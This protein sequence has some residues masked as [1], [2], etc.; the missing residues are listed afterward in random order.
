MAF[1]MLWVP[2]ALSPVSNVFFASGILL[3]ERTLYLASVGVC[4]G[5]GAIA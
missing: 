3:A 1:A 5:L 2:I 4:L